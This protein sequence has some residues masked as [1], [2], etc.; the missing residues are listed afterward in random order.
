[1]IKEYTNRTPAIDFGFGSTIL[2]GF[3]NIVTVWQNTIYHPAFYSPV[4]NVETPENTLP[5]TI[6]TI[7]P[8]EWRLTFEEPGAYYIR[9]TVPSPF[10]TT[11]KSNILTFIMK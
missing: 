3:D 11:L 2:E 6:E 10:G 4:I 9:V 1:M 8:Y 7:S 5:P